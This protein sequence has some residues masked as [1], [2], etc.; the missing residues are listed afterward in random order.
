MEKKLS[1]EGEWKKKNDNLSKRM[2]VGQI[3]QVGDSR[4]QVWKFKD[5]IANDKGFS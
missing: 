5:W 1:M 2:T 3:L 4:Y